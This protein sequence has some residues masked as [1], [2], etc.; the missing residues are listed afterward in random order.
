MTVR[1]IL[2]AFCSMY[3]ELLDPHRLVSKD[4]VILDFLIM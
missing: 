3:G 2:K 4:N 1:I